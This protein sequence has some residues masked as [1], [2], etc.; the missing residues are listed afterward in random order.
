MGEQ[1]NMSLKFRVFAIFVLVLA[2]L[3]G[4]VVAQGKVFW[5]IILIRIIFKDVFLDNVNNTGPVTFPPN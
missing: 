4:Q 2:M 1:L 3:W 5:Q